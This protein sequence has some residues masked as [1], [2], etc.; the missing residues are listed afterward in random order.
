MKKLLT[1]TCL[2]YYRKKNQLNAKSATKQFKRSTIT[3]LPVGKVDRHLGVTSLIIINTAGL[4]D[5]TSLVSNYFPNGSN[6]AIMI[7][8]NSQG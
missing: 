7:L 1:N 3:Y 2:L 8:A 6:K 4:P 5:Y